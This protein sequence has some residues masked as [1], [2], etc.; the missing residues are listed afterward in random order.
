MRVV[1]GKVRPD[2]VNSPGT[3][4]SR[5]DFGFELKTRIKVK[6]VVFL[7]PPGKRARGLGIQKAGGQLI[8][9]REKGRAARAR[10][11]ERATR[12]I[13]IDNGDARPTAASGVIRLRPPRVIVLIFSLAQ[14]LQI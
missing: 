6:L 7:G 10:S 3:L 2:S 8:K 12:F 13:R 14:R 1:A 11:G 9:P 4:T 5:P